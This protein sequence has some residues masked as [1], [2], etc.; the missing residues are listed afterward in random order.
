[1][2]DLKNEL[3]EEKIVKNS[4]K[5]LPTGIEALT[6]VNISCYSYCKPCAL[7]M[8]C[9]G[10]GLH[11]SGNLNGSYFGNEGNVMQAAFSAGNF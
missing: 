9:E 11:I 6:G 4:H 8:G 10:R 2:S 1:M 7:R 3:L 5:H